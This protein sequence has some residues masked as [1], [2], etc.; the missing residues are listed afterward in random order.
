ML[1][2]PLNEMRVY[3]HVDRSTT[4]TEDDVKPTESSSGSNMD[5]VDQPQLTRTRVSSSTLE[6][7]HAL[8]PSREGS[9]ETDGSS[10]LIESSP[11]AAGL[12]PSHSFP[13]AGS[14]PLG[15]SS[16]ESAGLGP[17]SRT[18]P[19]ADD[20]A[21]GT[22]LTRHY[23]KLLAVVEEIVGMEH[24]IRESLRHLEG[25]AEESAKAADLYAHDLDGLFAGEV[26]LDEAAERTATEAHHAGD[27]E[28]LEMT[29]ALSGA[30]ARNSGDEEGSE[31][32]DGLSAGAGSLGDSDGCAAAPAEKRS[33]E[34]GLCWNGTT[35]VSGNASSV[36][37]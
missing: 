13:A 32:T 2:F 15:E 9:P 37:M 10:P 4:P 35:C 18:S 19:E 12:S 11:D 33:C 16:P 14:A 17:L 25:P 1:F 30:G 27:V 6:R 20:S 26:H 22:P 36:M 29:A 24:P 8:S 31:M 3:A 23:P 34:N 7:L 21:T 28:A 5:R